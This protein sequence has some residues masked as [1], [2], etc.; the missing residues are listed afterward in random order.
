MRDYASPGSRSRKLTPQPD[1]SRLPRRAG[2]RTR[3]RP[4]SAAGEVSL[5]AA[6]IYHDAIVIDALNVSNWRSP[7]VYESLT[8]S[9]VTAINATLVTWENFQQT[10]DHI[11]HWQSIFRER[12]SQLIQIRSVDDILQAKRAEKAGVILGWQNMSPI[13]N[14]LRRIELF[15]SLGVLIMQLTFHERNL[16]GNGCMERGDAGL[17]NFG[18][19]AV[20]EMNRLG[21]LIDLSHCGERTTLDAIEMSAQPVACTHA[22]AQGF[23]NHPRNKPDQVLKLLAARGGVVGATAFNMFLPSGRASSIDDFVDA[24]DDLVQRI[25]VEHVGFGTDFTQDQPQSFWNYIG[26]QQGSKLPSTFFQESPGYAAL[27]HSPYGLETPDKLPY[28]A[29][30][31]SRRGYKPSDTSLLLGGNWLRLF[32]EVWAD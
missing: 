11:T 3:R 7:A 32:S 12:S 20:K 29:D 4:D 17:S 28:L 1:P 25:G 14:D 30:A 2:R 9:G 21:I 13:E 10:L 6:Q 31:L 24:I 8:A 18:V 16:I 23:H 26:S 5:S 27:S 19:D 22:N 15:H